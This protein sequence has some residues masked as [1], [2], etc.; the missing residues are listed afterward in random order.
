MIKFIPQAYD[1]LSGFNTGAISMNII[2]DGS[3]ATVTDSG[4]Y[5]TTSSTSTVTSPSYTSIS[6]TYTQ[7]SDTISDIYYQTTD[8]SI[9][10]LESSTS[11]SSLVLTCSSSGSSTITHSI[12]NY[13]SSIAPSWIS[14]DSSTSVLSMTTPNVDTNTE[15]D[16]YINSVSSG[17]SD[18]VQKLIKLTVVNCAV[19]NCLKWSSSSVSTC[20]VWASGFT[21]SSGTCVS[22]QSGTSSGSTSE[23]AKALGIFILVLIIATL[24]VVTALSLKNKT[25][26]WSFWSM[27]SQMQMLILVF[28][29]RSVTS[30]DIRKLLS[31]SNFT[32]NIYHYIYITNIRFYDWIFSNV[33]FDLTR[34]SLNEVVLDSD[35][36]IYNLYPVMTCILVLGLLHLVMYFVGK[37]IMKINTDGK[38]ASLIKI[39]KWI[40]S[41]LYR[42]M[43]FGF[44][45]RNA[46]LMCEF[47]MICSIYEI[48]QNNGYGTYHVVSLIFAYIMMLLYAAFTIWVFLLWVSS[49]NEN[50]KINRK[51]IEF[52]WGIKESKITQLYM[53]AFII[54]R[55]V[56]TIF[57]VG[58]TWLSSKV[59]F[60]IITAF[61]FFFLSCILI[62][63]PFKEIIVNAIEVLNESTLLLL[64]FI[65]NFFPQDGNWT[66]AQTRVYKAFIVLNFLLIFLFVWGKSSR[67]HV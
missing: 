33:K 37:Q 19:V 6:I 52:F 17:S 34:P 58:L 49:Y 38:C 26:M 56:Y 28:V 22:S 25:S 66:S 20:E 14:I 5:V 16:F 32:M 8:Q 57:F 11:S 23:E 55:A 29:S 21:L 63:R 12:G 54:R 42:I 64:L 30:E 27:V 31:T 2:S 48:F 67:H 9:S 10:V 1:E 46:F 40:L 60:G 61:Q 39:V 62:I 50:N 45:I 15:Y 41:K 44:Y 18:P 47:V 43:T 51:F 13:G 59:V 36:S 24:F 3:Y 4:H 65:L 7:A 35:G 53:V